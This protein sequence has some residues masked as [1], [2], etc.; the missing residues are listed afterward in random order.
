MTLFLQVTT[1]SKIALLH[2]Y[3]DELL[4]EIDEY[5]KDRLV[6]IKSASNESKNHLKKLVDESTTIV[7][8]WSNYLQQDK[9]NSEELG[10]SICE[11]GVATERLRDNVDVFTE[12][13]FDKSKLSLYTD[14]DKNLEKDYI[15]KLIRVKRKYE[16]EWQANDK[17]SFVKH[18]S[19]DKM[20]YEIFDDKVIFTF[21]LK[22]IQDREVILYDATRCTYLRITDTNVFFDTALEWFFLGNFQIRHFLYNGKWVVSPFSNLKIR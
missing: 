18:Y 19:D 21:K 13:V 1:E 3:K 2:R 20:W 14:T 17:H 4:A 7:N 22:K 8:K 15:C 6:S 11:T 16:F 12:F 5:E 10:Q 9:V